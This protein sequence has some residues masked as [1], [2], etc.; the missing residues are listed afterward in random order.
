MGFRVLVVLFSWTLK[1][2]CSQAIDS[3]ENREAGCPR[4]TMELNMSEMM[5]EQTLRRAIALSPETYSLPR[6]NLEAV[7][8]KR[9]A[10]R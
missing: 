9:V 7:L 6:G 1:E 4:R 5:I 8:E 10:G 3:Y 2:Q